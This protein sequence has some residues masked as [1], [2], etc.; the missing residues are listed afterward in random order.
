MKPGTHGGNA[1]RMKTDADTDFNIKNK[2]KSQSPVFD[3]IYKY[4]VTDSVLT[5]EDIYLKVQ[6]RAVPSRG[7]ARLHESVITRLGVEVGENIEVQ[8][9]PLEEEEHPKPLVLSAYADAMVEE[10]AIRMSTDD[11]A[12]LGVAEGDSVIVRR[13][14]PLTEV[15]GKKAGATGRA[16]Q[17]G[18][19]KAGKSIEEGVKDIGEKI[20]PGTGKKE[21]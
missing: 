19:G 8:R 11:I 13:K 12:R 3:I 10:D 17:E 9:Y 14:I 5:M 6:T 1:A 20:R 15:I 2:Y 18:A 7:R 16:V 4:N 21:P